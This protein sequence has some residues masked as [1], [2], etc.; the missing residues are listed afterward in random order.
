MRYI[1]LLLALLVASPA[2]AVDVAPA[3]SQLGE[4]C[5][6]YTMC[7]AETTEHST[8]ACDAGAGNIVA[9]ITTKHQ[10]SF[11][12]TASTA[13]PFVCMPY[14][15][16]A[17]H[18]TKRSALLASSLTETG[19]NASASGTFNRVWVACS[20]ITDGNITVTMDACP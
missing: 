10:L 5:I 7:D 6:R 9:N 1:I 14:L 2:L 13:T 18:A 3:S 11:D 8:N 12:A 17:H 4:N 20:T 15:G 19:Y 16:S